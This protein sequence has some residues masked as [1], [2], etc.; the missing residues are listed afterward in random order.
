MAEQQM[1]QASLH[2]STDIIELDLVRLWNAIW[3]RI[4]LVILAAALG[5]GAAFAY[6][7][8]FVTPTYSS[9]AQFYVNNYN[10]P[11]ETPGISSNDISSSKSLV[12]SY[13]VILKAAST[14]ND[15]LEYAGSDLSFSQ[16]R[17]MI[18]A[19]PVNNTE[20]F[21]VTVTSTDPEE[22]ANLANAI[23]YVVPKRIASIIEGSSAKVVDY[24]LIPTTRSAPSYSKNMMYGFL[25]GF[26]LA[27]GIIVL[28][29]LFDVT[30]KEEEDVERCSAYPV[31]AAVPDML[32][33]TKGS[34]RKRSYDV[35]PAK[36]DDKIIGGSISFAASEAYK[37]LRTK[38]QFS[39]T[40][41]KNCRV[42]AISSAMPGE[43]K[44][45]TAVNLA[46]SLAQLNKKVL[47]ID[48]DMRRPTLA[49]K[50]GLLKTPG[51][52]DYLTSK[53]DVEDVCQEYQIGQNMGSIRVITAGHTPPN[54]ME[55]LSSEKME[56]TLQKLEDL[57]DYIILDMPP[58]G[59]VSDAL[60]ATK[61]ADGILMV[62]R[63]NYCS[64]P[65]LRDAI[66]Q[67]TFVDAK[68]L[69]V[70]LNKTIED[71]VSYGRKY[72]YVRYYYRYGHRYGYRYGYRYGRK[73][74]LFYL[75][76]NEKS[77][78]S[79]STVTQTISEN[80]SADNK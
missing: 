39:F 22:A 20:I 75:Q 32:A 10:S 65:A 2:Q 80:H 42:F 66:Q 21:K 51:L 47:L 8:F 15:V 34:Y 59:E 6:T 79:E 14:L 49:E 36:K 60:T 13:I 74:H 30:I 72:R 57:F 45:I 56:W 48:C 18:N 70:L 44:S 33:P 25:L 9:T 17:N 63:Q 64:R 71:S 77:T 73:P 55:L 5:C 76:E 69:G 52:S 7:Y 23:A 1:N 78:S 12:E 19:A 54:P 37:L 46:C 53:L 11:D 26:I 61:L 27:V 35:E 4:I 29:E 3:R 16:L 41:G 31:L 24:A 68:I 62:V 43:G 67:F 40:D 58:I 38:L 50:T 28:R